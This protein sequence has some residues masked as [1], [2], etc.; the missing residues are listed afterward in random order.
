[1]TNPLSYEMFWNDISQIDETIVQGNEKF[2]KPENRSSTIFPV[3]KDLSTKTTIQF[4]SYW[5]KKT[6]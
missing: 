1:M 2:L 4:L 3:F 5:L 6:R